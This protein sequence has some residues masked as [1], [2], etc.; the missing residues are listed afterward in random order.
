MRGKGKE[1]DDQ[2]FGAW[3]RERIR[4]AGTNSRQLAIAMEVNPATISNWIGGHREP[5][6]ESCYKL[7]E[8][9]TLDLDEVLTRAGYREEGIVPQNPARGEAHRIIDRLPEGSVEIA[10]SYLRFV[11]TE[12]RSAPV[13][14][15]VRARG[16][17][18]NT[19]L[20]EPHRRDT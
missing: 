4:E 14:R 7:A 8:A 10:R 3:L 11:L 5:S 19:V 2:T 12:S 15:A 16:E 1:M 20:G 9:L 6:M 18:A 17:R 13:A